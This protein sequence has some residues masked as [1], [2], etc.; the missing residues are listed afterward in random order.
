MTK[1]V[2]DNNYEDEPKY[3]KKTKSN[4]SKSSNKSKHKHQYK[5]CLIKYPFMYKSE[6]CYSVTPASYCTVCGKIGGNI[7]QIPVTERLEDG[8][9][10]MYRSEEILEMNKDL[11]VFEVEDVTQKYI[12]IVIN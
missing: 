12:S 7:L 3:K 6:K 4:T 9:R 2:K 5:G 10:R 11:E 8:C 1:L